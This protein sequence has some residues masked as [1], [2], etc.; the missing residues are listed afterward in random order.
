MEDYKKFF[1]VSH[2]I[3]DKL[4]EKGLQKLYF[5]T[6]KDGKYYWGLD[7]NSFSEEQMKETEKMNQLV[8]LPKLIEVERN[9]GKTLW[10]DSKGRVYVADVSKPCLNMAG[11]LEGIILK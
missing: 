2:I 11:L 6:K 8:K 4:P 7:N 1:Y 9:N 10:T 3:I 5:Y